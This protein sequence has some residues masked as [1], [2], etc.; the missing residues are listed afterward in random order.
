MTFLDTQKTLTGLSEQL[1]AALRRS[2]MVW[3]GM[4]SDYQSKYAFS[5]DYDSG[6]KQDYYDKAVACHEAIA[7]VE[8]LDIPKSVVGVPAFVEALQGVVTQSAWPSEMDGV[9]KQL[10]KDLSQY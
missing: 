6:F 2:E 1:C 7:Y 4:A 3:Y 10:V 5:A 8:S 9:V